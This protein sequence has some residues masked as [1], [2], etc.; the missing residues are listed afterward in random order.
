MPRFEVHA[1]QVD[2]MIFADIYQGAKLMAEGVFEVEGGPA[3][4]QV[5]VDFIEPIGRLPVRLLECSREPHLLMLEVL[6]ERRKGEVR[7]WWRGECEGWE[8]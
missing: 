4:L 6:A 2:Q 7:T 1:L 5:V 3:D 8:W